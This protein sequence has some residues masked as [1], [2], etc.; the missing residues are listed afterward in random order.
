MNY[1][2]FVVKT[3]RATSIG[4]RLALLAANTTSTTTPTTTPT[5]TLTVTVT[6]TKRR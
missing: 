3:V 5:T 2:T 4:D 1:M 6:V